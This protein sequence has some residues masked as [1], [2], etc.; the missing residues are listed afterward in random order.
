MFQLIAVDAHAAFSGGS[1]ELGLADTLKDMRKELQIHGRWN[2]G[3]VKAGDARPKR[4]S[5]S[6]SHRTRMEHAEDG[7]YTDRGTD[8]K[9]KARSSFALGSNT[10]ACRLGPLGPRRVVLCCI[11]ADTLMIGTSNYR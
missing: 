6:L 10:P 9:S 7:G 1:P 2:R 11:P 3:G 8:P 4:Q 5:P